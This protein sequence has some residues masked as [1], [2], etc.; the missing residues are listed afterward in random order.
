MVIKSKPW[1]LHRLVSKVARRLMGTITHVITK[2][3]VIALTFDDGPHPESTPQ[4]LDILKRY[5][6]R[7]TFFM[8]GDL[9]QRYPR[10]VRHVAQAGHA[11]GNHSWDH[12][13]FPFISA[14][15][16]RAQIRACQ[17]ALAPYGCRIFRPPYGDQTFASRLDALF[18]QQQVVTWNVVA[19]DWLDHDANW[20]VDYLMKKFM[21]GSIVVFHD[22]LYHTLEDHYANREPVFQAI[23]MLLKQLETSFNFVPVPEL[24][25]YG[26]PKKQLWYKKSVP[27]WLN[28][29]KSQVGRIRRYSNSFEKKHILSIR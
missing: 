11:I 8:V 3:N 17:K 18:T 10:L 26:R 2:D 20:Y 19:E 5:N 15:E 14:R 1:I 4:L 22:T 9:A 23:D 21:P 12:P 16:R 25:K 6:A 27:Q 13:S 7:A 24:L 28:R 29:H